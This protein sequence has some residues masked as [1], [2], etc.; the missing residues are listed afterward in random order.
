VPEVKGERRG[1]AA[2]GVDHGVYV[3]GAVSSAGERG[4][5]YVEGD[6]LRSSD[7]FSRDTPQ[8]KV[9]RRTY[10]H[11]RAKEASPFGGISDSPLPSPLPS[12]ALGGGAFGGLFSPTIGSEAKPQAQPS[13]AKTRQD[14]PELESP[15]L[16]S[17][18]EQ[19]ALARAQLSAEMGA[20][21]DGADAD[22]AEGEEDSA[23]T[24]IRSSVRT[25]CF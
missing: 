19:A 25:L 3:T 15:L 17:K 20:E 22:E 10:L 11:R 9:T 13:Q 8:P 6:S 2:D 18:F 24:Q 4:A 23:I 5:S 7:D 21:L 14:K 1:G 12:P 16:S